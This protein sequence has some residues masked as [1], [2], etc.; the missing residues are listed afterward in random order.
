M[1]M[2]ES[3]LSRR[4]ILFHFV[5][6]ICFSERHLLIPGS[7]T[8]AGFKAKVPT[9]V[10]LLIV[11]SSCVDFSTLNPKKRHELRGSPLFPT[12]RVDPSNPVPTLEAFINS[13]QGIVG[14]SAVTFVS[15]MKYV[16]RVRP[17]LVI[18]ENVNSAPWDNIAN[19]YFPM[20]QYCAMHVSVDSRD[21]GVPQT[22]QRGYCVAADWTY[23]GDRAADIVK[24]WAK[25]VKGIA[26]NSQI[27]LENLLLRP[28]DRAVREMEIPIERGTCRE[29]SAKATM[30]KM[31]HKDARETHALPDLNPVTGIDERGTCKPDDRIFGR[32]IQ[33]QGG[34]VCDLLDI[35]WMRT[36]I[37]PNLMFDARYKLHI[38]DLSQNVDRSLGQVGQSPCVTPAG[39]QFITGQG[40]PLLGS[41]AL[42]FQGIDS[43]KLVSS[44]ESEKDWRDLAG[45]AMTT[46]VIGSAILAA[47][48][49]E[50]NVCKDEPVG[51]KAP[52]Y[53]VIDDFRGE[54]RVEC[55]HTGMDDV[56]N[57][58]HQKVSK[59]FAVSVEQLLSLRQKSRS[60]C[61]CDGLGIR[62][63]AK[64]LLQCIDCGEI[65]CKFCAGNP[66]HEFVPYPIDFRL[67]SQAET[68]QLLGSLFP[69]KF[70]LT[71]EEG[72]A[73]LQVPTI[74]RFEESISA[75]GR[76]SRASDRVS[77]AFKVCCR[78]VTYYYDSCHIGQDLTVFYTSER[79]FAHVVVTKTAVTWTIYM[80]V[81]KCRTI[82][83]DDAT[84][85][86]CLRAVM[87]KP[88]SSYIPSID[89]WLLWWDDHH[90]V[91]VE[92]SENLD[93]MRGIHY[94]ILSI[95]DHQGSKNVDP[96]VAEIVQSALSQTYELTEKCGTSH[97]VLYFSRSAGLYHFIQPHPSKDGSNDRFVIAHSNR[98]LE[99]FEQR[100]PL[101]IF[102][103]YFRPIKSKWERIHK[104][105]Q[106]QKKR[107]D[108]GATGEEDL[109]SEGEQPCQVPQ[110]SEEAMAMVV[111]EAKSKKVQAVKSSP[112]DSTEPKTLVC[113]FPGRWVGVAPQYLHRDN[114]T[115]TEMSDVDAPMHIAPQ[116]L[117]LLSSD[118]L[119]MAKVNR[120][121]A[122]V[123]WLHIVT[124][125]KN[126]PWKNEAHKVLWKPAFCVP[127]DDD[128]DTLMVPQPVQCSF[129]E[130][131]THNHDDLL[132]TYAFLFNALPVHKGTS[133]TTGTIDLSTGLCLRCVPEP[134]TLHRLRG[135]NHKVVDVL[136][137]VVE[138]ELFEKKINDRPAPLK[139]YVGIDDSEE[140]MKLHI[141]LNLTALL[142][143]ASG[144]LPREGV[145]MDVHRDPSGIRGT[146]RIVTNFI[147]S[148]GIFEPF[149]T[150]LQSIT[151]G[152]DKPFESPFFDN[153]K[154]D[155]YSPQMDCVRWMISR[156]VEP[157]PFIEAE[158]EEHHEK[159]I[160]LRLLGRATN[161]NSARGGILA[162]EV[163]FG[164]TVV[165]L[166]LLNRQRGRIDDSLDE[167]RK[168]CGGALLHAKATLIIVPLHI[169]DQWVSEIRKFLGPEKT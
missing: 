134:P 38:I 116:D 60:Y 136:E 69:P 63:R 148:P 23:Y 52:A 87:N 70:T 32:W 165:T 114:E 18:L 82:V 160:G 85:V 151:N 21:Y 12:S 164:K 6:Y 121:D 162:H 145:R 99:L 30:C 144:H 54:G 56:S 112:F 29:P 44:T 108:D 65:R 129:F 8:A 27:P 55:N 90:Y 161:K 86:P 142:H 16:L 68:C 159:R 73:G 93:R 95:K 20:A 169:V 149:E 28:N 137:D 64:N 66:R 76:F 51:L 3:P 9:T 128:G 13:V 130:V 118:P 74:G 4:L 58:Y 155:L 31:R 105:L 19:D 102:P 101:L 96:V 89:D 117:V 79:S 143:R 35:A 17:K 111:K 53:D 127:H 81:P 166:A 57:A 43:S 22:R 92:V 72:E 39:I 80:D 49:A 147:D 84:R 124:P 146:A 14:E 103:Q 158:V 125:L 140:G 123:R 75:P 115:D 126:V 15:S 91:E 152:S 113:K 109:K 106:S 135:P 45:N 100:E 26:P 88:Q 5:A 7:T 33:K 36:M 138:C 132:S 150:A 11:G 104:K 141:K 41:E 48:V 154:H 25:I 120:C 42:A 97:G 46:T 2:R 34:R 77:K 139:L 62:N 157:E 61:P 71:T 131:S 24:E 78:S 10:D 67:K 163:G 156:E 83:R 153:R 50:W 37:T 167:R 94:N 47:I 1:N 59:L 40:R 110:K 168:W 107:P 119:E 98:P 133:V 122:A